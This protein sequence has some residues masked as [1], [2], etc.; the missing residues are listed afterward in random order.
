MEF[1]SHKLLRQSLLLKIFT[2]HRC[3]SPFM[4]TFRTTKNKVLESL[5]RLLNADCK[6]KGVLQ[7]NL[8]D[9]WK[10]SVKLCLR[11]TKPVQ[12]S[13]RFDE[14]FWGFFLEDFGRIW[15]HF[16]RKCL[17]EISVFTLLLLI[18]LLGSDDLF[19]PSRWCKDL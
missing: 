9:C 17:F 13:F 15:S 12:N 6:I 3:L 8:V 19:S 5:K 10:K 1:L 14:F 11:S 4:A 18:Q 2:C 7:L 16:F